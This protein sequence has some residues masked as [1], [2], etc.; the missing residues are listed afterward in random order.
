ME[1]VTDTDLANVSL[2]RCNQN[3]FKA[4]TLNDIPK[5][6]NS[7]ILR[8]KE[9][10]DAEAWFEFC[11]IYEPLI[12]RIARSRGLQTADATDLAQ[13]VFVRIAKSVRRWEPDPTK[14]SFRG[15]ISTI[16]RNL[17]IDFLRQQDRRPLSASDPTLASIK[18]PCAES[19]FYDIEFEKQVFAW[20][21]KRI[22][23]SFQPHT[24]QAFWQT[25]VE[26]RPIKEVAESLGL[27]TGVIYLAR[28]RVIAKLRTTIERTYDS[29]FSFDSKTLLTESQTMLTES[30]TQGQEP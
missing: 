26:Q 1:F 13:D 30:Q 2:T 4:N 16:A 8:L 17:T 28:S 5:T 9:P 27:S 11:E 14:G 24:W 15:W 6:R 22:Q 12:L 18:S 21:A 20:A 29:H 7:L 19:D 3:C 25:T 10:A 23:A